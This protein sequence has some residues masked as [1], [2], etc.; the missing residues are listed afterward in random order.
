[1]EN[2]LSKWILGELG[3]LEY[4][5]KRSLWIE[6][7]DIGEQQMGSAQITETINDIRRYADKISK[8]E[9]WLNNEN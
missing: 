9:K 1:M 6:C 4:N 3:W 2:G 7:T 5:L 8:L